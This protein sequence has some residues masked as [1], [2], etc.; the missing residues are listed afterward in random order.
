MF[1]RTFCLIV[2]LLFCPTVLMADWTV[3]HGPNRDNVSPETGLLKSWQESGPPLLWRVNTIGTT[4]FP[5]YSSVTVSE[6]RV[7]TA[8]NVRTGET[9]QDAH[10]Y[11]FALDEKTGEEIWRYRNGIAWTDRTRYPGERS[12]P[13]ID[14]ERLYVFSAVGRIACIEA[15]TGK[16][17]WARDLREEYD[18]ELPEWAFA[19]SPFVD[20]NKVVLWIGSERAA[21]V[22]LDKM[23]GETIWETPPTGLTGNYASMTAFDHGGQRI[24]VNM[25]KK[26]LIGVN[27]DTGKNLFFILHETLMGNTMATTP[28]FFDG[29]LFITSGYGVGSRL[30]R[31]DVNGETVTPV[32]IWSNRNFDNRL[33]GVVIKDGYV[34]GSTHRHGNSRNWMCVRLADGE[35]MWENPGVFIGPV[36]SADGMLY[37]I[38]ERTGEV[39]LV[40][41]TPERYEEMSRFRLP[42]EEE[43]GGVG[44]FWAHPV[45][46]N[47]KLFIRHGNILY[48]FDIA[49]RG[50]E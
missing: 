18:V 5:G 23:T 25:N 45:V 12:T 8:G 17:I 39:A 31:L 40:R 44:M 26:G 1:F 36:T 42:S 11:G 48:C 32:L 10:V 13:T 30:Y 47:K 15:A 3:F 33:G 4:E 38:S 50:E 43:G 24:Y 27:G 41:A 35:I 6:G 34:Y 14:G 21:V 29:K 37:C 28:Y 46:V 2:L 20:R 22:A 49:G 16:E 19:E 9:D 7:F